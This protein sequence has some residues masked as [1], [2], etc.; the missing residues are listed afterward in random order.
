MFDK[1][2]RHPD[3]LERANGAID[4]VTAIWERV[5]LNFPRDEVLEAW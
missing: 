3:W 1:R 4:R 5:G 2:D